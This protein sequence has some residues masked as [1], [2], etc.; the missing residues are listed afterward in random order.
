MAVVRPLSALAAV[1]RPLVWLLG[2][3]TDMAVRLAGSD[4]RRQHEDITPA[5]IYRVFNMGLG[6]V[7]VVSPY[8]ADSVR[9]QLADLGFENWTIGRVQSGPRGVVWA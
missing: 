5:E 1:S 8:Y 3:S 9:S 4:P 6:L 2:R 7:M